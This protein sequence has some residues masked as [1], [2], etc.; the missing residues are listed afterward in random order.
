MKRLVCILAVLV[1]ASAYAQDAVPVN[2]TCRG[3]TQKEAF[4]DCF[5]KALEEVSGN[6][7]L[8]VLEGKRNQITKDELATY[9]AGY[10]DKYKVTNFS[11]DKNELVVSMTVWVRNSKMANHKLNTAKDEKEIDGKRLDTQYSTYQ[12][13]RTSADKFLGTILNDFPSK[14]LKIQQLSTPQITI[15]NQR[16]LTI[17]V[18]YKASWN[19]D[20]LISLKEA[21][22]NLQDGAEYYDLSC[23]CYRSQEKIK[24]Y[25][26]TGSFLRGTDSYFFKDSILTGKIQ[27]KFDNLIRIKATV[28]DDTDNP[29]IQNCYATDSDTH[30]GFSK[31][32]GIYEVNGHINE[33]SSVLIE[34]SADNKLRPNFDK[35]TRIELSM[36]SN[37]QCVK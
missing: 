2:V 13:E 37:T 14:A 23:L 26:N 10:V 24:I 1:T 11:K 34:V 4:N 20:Y 27:R 9:T 15:D 16:K 36:V 30:W 5:Q 7:V 6:V 17:E 29:I 19:Q 21:L 35:A 25:S 31:R 28:Y 18:Y 8:S 33:I 22:S 32:G 12:N 3:Q